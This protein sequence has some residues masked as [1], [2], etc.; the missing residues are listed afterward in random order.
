[1]KTA[2]A[3]LPVA[4]LLVLGTPAPADDDAID[5][6][7]R[8]HAE[9]LESPS[10]Y[11]RAWAGEHLASTKDARALSALARSYSRLPQPRDQAQY[12]LASACTRH[13]DSAEFVPGLIAWRE[14]YARPE[15][16]WL[17]YRTLVVEGQ[18]NGAPELV[19]LAADPHRNAFL[20]AAALQACA[21]LRAPESLETLPDVLASLPREPAH[22]AALLTGCASVLLSMGHERGNAMRYVLALRLM[23][24]LD[25]KATPAVTSVV[26][27]RHFQRIFDVSDAFVD[28]APWRRVLRSVQSLMEIPPLE[29]RQVG[30]VRLAGIRARG[31]RIAYVLDLAQGAA[32]EATADDLA[33]LALS[34]T[35]KAVSRKQAMLAALRSSLQSLSPEQSFAVIVSRHLASGLAPSC[36][37]MMPATRKNVAA[38]LD[39]LASLEPEGDADLHT[40]LRQAFALTAK[41]IAKG[42]EYVAGAA[43]LEGC[44]TVFVLAQCAPLRDAWVPA[45]D[46]PDDPPRWSAAGREI[47]GVYSDEAYLAEELRR[48]NLFRGAEI[49]AVAIGDAPRALFHDL[50]RPYRGWNTMEGL[51]ALLADQDAAAAPWVSVRNQYLAY[52]ERPSLF[53]R[54][55]GRRRLATTGD[56]RALDLLAK[57]Y[58]RPEEPKDRIPHLLVSLCARHFEDAEHLPRFHAWREKHRKAFD[59][60]LWHRTAVLDIRKG[61]PSIVERIALQSSGH[62]LQLAA[63]RALAAERA[64]ACVPVA[65]DLLGRLPAGRAQ[66]ASMLEAVAA[67]LEARSDARS[68]KGYAAP[69]EALI[70]ILRDDELP[71]RTRHVILRHLARIFDADLG[72]GLKADL[73]LRE[74]RGAQAAPSEAN[75]SVD[76]RYAPF[77]FMGI[78]SP[79]TRVCYVIDAS[80]SMLEPISD[81]DRRRLSQV[82]TGSGSGDANRDA[83]PWSRIHTRFDVAREFLKLSLRRLTRDQA[84]SV[85]LFGTD[86]RTLPST[87]SLVSATPIALVKAIRDLDAIKPGPKSPTRPHGTLRGFTN[88]HGG[89]ALAFRLTGGGTA[90]PDPYVDPAVLLDGVDTIYLLSDGDPSTDDYR[91]VDEP[92]LGDAQA[93][94]ET[95]AAQ[96][97]VPDVTYYGPYV[98]AEGFLVDDVRR[99]NLFRNAAIHCVGIGDADVDLLEAIAGVG[100]GEVLR[101]ASGN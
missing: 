40:G 44:D 26:I 17:W 32:L 97:K 25:S 78:P 80:D 82:V 12:L 49:H 14:K 5:E 81:D 96:E 61:D 77:E 93:D 69:A 38:V 2:I 10:L 28:A 86:A 83:L 45:G 68:T 50:F 39:G 6:A 55:R 20:R 18:C 33:T 51:E 92:D 84:F 71:L 27:A 99:M 65:K 56:P 15:H 95:R 4:L 67:L 35:A 42:A 70:E 24:Q 37:G 48:L 19:A 75:P 94:P 52:L 89:L 23:G 74:L 41:G 54:M 73:W 1:M 59:A 36:R 43:L 7:L 76:D 64:P 46:P 8:A 3:V 34:P 16:A 72:Y 13:F 91:A 101:L 57:S 100:L 11:R 9:G 62:Y 22:R 21:T 31:N 66:R 85:V 30:P 63:I 53:M 47:R 79:G 29:G 90:G 58:A 87:P 88:M 60:W 98:D